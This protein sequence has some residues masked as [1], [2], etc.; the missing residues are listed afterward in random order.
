MQLHQEAKIPISGKTA[1][2]FEPM[3][4]FKYPLGFRN[5]QVVQHSLIMTVL[6]YLLRFGLGGAVTAV[7]KQDECLI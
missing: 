1:V 4:Q 7:D 5:F 3:R 6:Y 2:T